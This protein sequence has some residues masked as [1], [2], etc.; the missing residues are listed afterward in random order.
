LYLVIYSLCM[1][2]LSADDYHNEAEVSVLTE[3]FKTQL[4]IRE[5]LFIT[6]K[7]VDLFITTKVV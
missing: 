6:T 1:V 3:E 4:T 2:T 7:V 5:D